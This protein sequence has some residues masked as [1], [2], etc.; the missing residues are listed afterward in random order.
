MATVV[1]ASLVNVAGTQLP[2]WTGT[3]KPA[4]AQEQSDWSK[5]NHDPLV[6]IIGGFVIGGFLIA[7]AGK[8]PG[9][10]EAFAAAFL[11]T[12]LLLNGIPL[13]NAASN[14][15]TNLGK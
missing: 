2:P 13:V 8:L 7:L 3:G 11:I 1:V 5:H 15:S 12:S 10:A 14:L 6:P 4:T 9:L